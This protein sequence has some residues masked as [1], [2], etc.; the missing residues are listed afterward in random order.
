MTR[1]GA[2]RGSNST[3]ALNTRSLDQARMGHP[4]IKHR[5]ARD[6]KAGPTIRE[7]E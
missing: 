4:P 2:I 3:K 6:G 5:P 7:H 1:H